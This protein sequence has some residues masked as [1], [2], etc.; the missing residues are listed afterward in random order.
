MSRSCPTREQTAPSAL[1]ESRI[2]LEA[3]GRYQT[4]RAVDQNPVRTVTPLCLRRLSAF[5]L[6]CFLQARPFISIDGLVLQSAAAWIAVQQEADGRMREPGRVIH[7]ELQGGLDGPV[8]LTSYVLIALLED[9]LIR[10]RSSKCSGPDGMFPSELAVMPC[11]LSD[12]L[13]T[14]PRR[15]P[16]KPT[17]RP[18]W[19]S[20]FPAT[21]ASAFSPTL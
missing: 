14:P 18:A 3:P 15:L 4:H 2:L 6:R 11:S 21:T 17:W 8:S 7:T 10:V 1:L 13:S 19:P 9:D 20:E 16:P 12:R 5:V